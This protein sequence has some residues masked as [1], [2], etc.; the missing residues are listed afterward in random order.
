ML[1]SRSIKSWSVP[2]VLKGGG[3]CTTPINEGEHSTPKALKPLPFNN[4]VLQI[5]LK[6][7]NY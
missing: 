4:K 6:F 5:S 7:Y 1:P 3:F 2:K